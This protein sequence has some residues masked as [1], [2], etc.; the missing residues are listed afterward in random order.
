VRFAYSADGGENFSAPLEIDRGKAVLGAVDVTL[1]SASAWL[2][3]LREEPAGQSL[4]LARIA[5]GGTHEHQRQQLATI[6][7]RGRATG[8]PK[9]ASL[10]GQLHVVWT[11]LENERPVLRGAVIETS[12]TGLRS[13]Q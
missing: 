3:W 11:D 10:G 12:T 9:T 1:E 7:G 4:W 5:R 6:A 2:A 8:L 13:G